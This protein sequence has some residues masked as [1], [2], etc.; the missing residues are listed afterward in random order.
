LSGKK[1]IRSIKLK[2]KD[3]TGPSKPEVGVSKKTGKPIKPRKPE[4]K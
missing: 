1:N 3:K 4:K 2:K